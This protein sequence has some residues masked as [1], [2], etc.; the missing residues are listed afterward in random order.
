MQQPADMQERVGDQHK[1]RQSMN[2]GAVGRSARELGAS[3]H[4][5]N[6]SA[7]PGFLGSMVVP[8]PG[9]ISR[10]DAIYSGRQSGAGGSKF[11]NFDLKRQ[12]V[13]RCGASGYT[14]ETMEL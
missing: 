3:K 9:G 8:T 2:E 5:A 11:W 10:W 4:A 7:E 6:E 12:R 13:S 14:L 1:G